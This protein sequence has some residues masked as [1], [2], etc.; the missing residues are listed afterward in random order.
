MLFR[1]GFIIAG[2]GPVPVQI[3]ERLECGNSLV[4]LTLV[5]IAQTENIVIG[6]ALGDEFHSPLCLCKSQVEMALRVVG[7]RQVLVSVGMIGRKPDRLFRLSQRLV[8][9]PLLK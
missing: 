8:N 4:S 9:L 7:E 1:S 5:H 2:V 6:V 3:Q